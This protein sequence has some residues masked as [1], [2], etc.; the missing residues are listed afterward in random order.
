MVRGYCQSCRMLKEEVI[1]NDSDASVVIPDFGYWEV[2]V[3][4][5]VALISLGPILGCD[6][7]ESPIRRKV[8]CPFG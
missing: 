6:G 3:Y 2:G 1:G 5:A 7:M 8:R 4:V